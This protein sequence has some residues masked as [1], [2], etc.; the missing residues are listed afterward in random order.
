MQ[1]VVGYEININDLFNSPPKTEDVH[2]NN[3]DKSVKYDNPSTAGYDEE[4]GIYAY[5]TDF[6]KPPTVFLKQYYRIL[7]AVLAFFACLI[8]IAIIVFLVVPSTV[9]HT[10]SV[11]LD[12]QCGQDLTNLWLDV[13]VVVDNSKGMTNDGLQYI[14]ATIPTVFACTRIGT[15]YA[16]PRTTRVGI[17]T[18]NTDATVNADLNHFQSYDD[19][20]N[21]VY[22]DLSSVSTSEQSYLSTGLQAA[23]HMIR[24]QNMNTTRGHYKKVVIVYASAYEGTGELDPLPVANRLTENGVY[25]IT[26]VYDQGGDEGLLYQL[27]DIATPGMAFNNTGS[28]GIDFVSNIQQ[29][30]LQAN[31]FCPSGWE[32]YRTTFSDRFSFH[33]GQCLKVVTIPAT[34]DDSRM[35]CKNRTTNSYLA[36]EQSQEKHDFILEYVK[37]QKG[38]TMPYKYNIG[39]SWSTTQNWWTWEQPAGM[40]PVPNGPPVYDGAYTNWGYQNPVERSN[41]L[42]VQNM[43]S[44]TWSY[45][46]NILQSTGS[47]PYV[48]EA[49]SCD[50][51]NYCDADD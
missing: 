29:A 20:S 11:N 7:L 25:I 28:V 24:T 17:V 46:Q 1:E 30:L 5:I 6:S 16:D 41:M 10:A 50:T 40:A 21:A 49:Y 18:Y 45:W 3:D 15:N 26:V 2:N 14:A 38:M 39:L 9:H 48:C 12:R 4:E 27:A 35:N 8:A 33:Y 19:F 43:Q 36:T 13:V 47:S 37:N 42:G 22:Q 32:Q 34:W 51:D 44:G 23:E 31:C